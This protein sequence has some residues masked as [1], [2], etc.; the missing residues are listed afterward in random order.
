VV[1][2]SSKFASSGLVTVRPAT[3]TFSKTTP[4][5]ALSGA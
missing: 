5:M 4:A 3:V 1:G 2:S